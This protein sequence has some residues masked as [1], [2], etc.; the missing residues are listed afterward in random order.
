MPSNNLVKFRYKRKINQYLVLILKVLEK[1]DIRMPFFPNYLQI[2][3]T[4]VPTC[5]PILA[6]ETCIYEMMFSKFYGMFQFE[7]YVII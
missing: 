1:N 2:D 4:L 5:H 7:L 6:N 3:F